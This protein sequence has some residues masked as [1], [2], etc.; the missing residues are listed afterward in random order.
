MKPERRP[1]PRGTPGVLE[2]PSGLRVRGRGLRAGLPDGDAPTLAVHLS[3][4]RPAAVP[5]EALW[6]RWP[7]FWVPTDPVDALSVLRAAHARAGTERLEL[8]C[9]GGVGRTG[10]ALAVLAVFDGLS[11]DE[12]VRWVRW[13]YHRRAV[14]VPWQRLLPA[15]AAGLEQCLAA[16]GDAGR[17]DGSAGPGR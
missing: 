8:A 1:W 9:G 10:T 6:V 4:R 13:R 7:D 15:R 3:R 5:W 11:P 17:T 2:L 16:E 12:A 14:E